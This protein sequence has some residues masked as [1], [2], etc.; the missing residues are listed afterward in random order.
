VQQLAEA[1]PLGIPVLFKSNARNHI[2]PDA[3]AGINEAAGAFSA[4]PK[5]AGITAAALGEEARKTGKAPAPVTCQ[6][7]A[8]SP[9]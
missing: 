9:K 8:S 5:G 3:R 6:S 2:E 1:T 7:Y 4:F